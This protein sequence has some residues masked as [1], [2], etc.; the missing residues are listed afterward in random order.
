MGPRLLC[1]P[2]ISAMTERLVLPPL[3]SVVGI[4]ACSGC[5]GEALVGEHSSNA[6]PSPQELR[7]TPEQVLYVQPAPGA[8]VA[9]PVGSMDLPFASI[10][11]ARDHIRALRWRS[12]GLFR[13]SIGPGVYPP[14]H[15]EPQDSGCPGAPVVYEGR[16]GATIS[17]GVHIPPSAFQ[18]WDGHPGMVQADLSQY[19]L[20]YGEFG[21]GG[22]TAGTCVQ[23]TKTRLIFENRTQVLARW[24]NVLKFSPSTYQWEKIT[25]DNWVGTGF[26]IFYDTGAGARV[27]RWAAE[28]EPLVHLYGQ[29]DWI[30]S[31]S[32]VTLTPSSIM[33]G[34]NITGTGTSLAVLVGPAKFYAANLLSELDVANEYYIDEAKH[35]LYFAPP[36]PLAQWTEG[37]Y[38]T[39]HLAAANIAADHVTLRN[40]AIR[41]SRG[42]G[43]VAMNVTGAEPCAEPS[44]LR[45]KRIPKTEYLPGQARDNHWKN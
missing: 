30:D 34:M 14:L 21:E 41:H 22:D 18:P 16:E 39:Q 43:V 3:L 32:R 5:V 20:T 37:V 19:N 23:F 26:V 10:H 8:A 28:P 27:R 13:V 11:D 36:T 24:P 4:L 38:L 6:C 25:V 2:A 40:L 9:A 15:L 1:T 45:Q 7:S 17:G 29:Y 12:P 31:W 42:N 35:M 44:F 33:P